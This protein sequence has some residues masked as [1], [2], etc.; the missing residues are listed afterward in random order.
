MEI[1]NKKIKCANC[2]RVL[3]KGEK[4]ILD[5]YFDNPC[6]EECYPILKQSMIESEDWIDLEVM[7]NK[8]WEV[9]K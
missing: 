9:V 6:C 3:E 2:G 8:E 1:K 4:Y 5:P 7:E